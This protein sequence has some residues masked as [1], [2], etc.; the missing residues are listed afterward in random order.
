V[1]RDVS[2]DRE[3]YDP[4]DFSANPLQEWT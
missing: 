3:N 2:R 1:S 4:R